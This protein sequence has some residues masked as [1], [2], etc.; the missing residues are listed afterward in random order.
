MRIPCG[1]EGERP[2]EA[3]WRYLPADAGAWYEPFWVR[4]WSWQR[5]LARGVLKE[6]KVVYQQWRGGRM[7][8]RGP[9]KP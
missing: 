2:E 4:W 6:S 7:A 9:A 5:S 3:D 1:P 8:R